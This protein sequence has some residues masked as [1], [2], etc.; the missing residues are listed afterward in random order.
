[1]IPEHEPLPAEQTF[2]FS[3]STTSFWRS[4]PSI[5]DNYRSTPE[6]P[7]EVDVAIIGAG[8]SGVSTAYHI[9][10]QSSSS[11]SI[12]ILEARQLCSGATGRNGGH[13]KVA[14]PHYSRIL[15]RCGIDAARELADFHFHQLYAMK[16]VVERERIDCDLLCTRSFDV[17]MDEMMAE[18]SELEVQRLRD[19]GVE[20]VRREVQILSA[21][22]I[23]AVCYR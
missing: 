11:P 20:V 5:L 17:F 1:M 19:A 16:E 3:T 18:E 8:L 9:L 21:E 6:L 15:E 10:Q 4:Q 14:V 23:E 2:P 13:L 22:A 7:T 12:A